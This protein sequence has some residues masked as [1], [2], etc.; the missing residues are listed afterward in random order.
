MHSWCEAKA[1]IVAIL[2]HLARLRE[3]LF[4]LFGAKPLSNHFFKLSNKGSDCP[5]L[6]SKEAEPKKKQK[7][8]TLKQYY[9]YT[10]TNK[11]RK[12][13]SVKLYSEIEGE[14]S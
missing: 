3:N 11:Y 12:R 10:Q 9:V 6:F 8:K 14:Q 7:K 13:A 4:L 1:D 5:T 2:Y